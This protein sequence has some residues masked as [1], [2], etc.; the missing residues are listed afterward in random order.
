MGPGPI[1]VCARSLTPSLARGVRNYVREG[2][3]EKL[4]VDP[5]P[6]FCVSETVSRPSSRA[7][8]PATPARLNSRPTPAALL[9]PGP[10]H[11]PCEVGSVPRA[12]LQQAEA[13]RRRGRGSD[14]IEPTTLGNGIIIVN[15]K[16]QKH[17]PDHRPARQ[18]SWQPN[19]ETRK[20]IHAPWCRHACHQ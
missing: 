17:I 18:S 3:C 5:Q 8:P 1:A 13:R 6:F 20:I 4:G 15:E 10:C 12:A 16:W 7:R 9:T 2:E 19:Q 14:G 11:M